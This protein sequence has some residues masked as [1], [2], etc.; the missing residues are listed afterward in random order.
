MKDEQNFEVELMS[1]ESKFIELYPVTASGS[2]ILL[3]PWQRGYA[4]DKGHLQLVKKSRR[5][6]FTFVEAAKGL[7]RSQT[8]ISDSIPYAYEKHFISRNLGEAQEFITVARIIY[9]CLP[10]Q[11]RLRIVNET[12]REL[13]FEDIRGRRTRLKAHTANDPRGIGGDL[14]YDEAAFLRNFSKLYSAG[15]WVTARGGDI[16]IGSSPGAASGHFYE[17]CENKD[18]RFSGFRRRNIPWWLSH[19]LC[20]DVARAAK[21]ASSMAT[22]D[23]VYEFGTPEII[24]IFDS[25]AIADFQQ[26]SE[27]MY[28][29]ES[30]TFFPYELIGSCSVGEFGADMKDSDVTMAFSYCKDEPDESFWRWVKANTKGRL[31]GGFDVG[32]RRDLS[33]LVLTDAYSGVREVRAVVTLDRKDF[34]SQERVINDCIRIAKPMVIR[35]E[36]NGL[37]MEMGERLKKQWG[38]LIELVTSSAPWKLRAATHLKYLFEKRGIRIPDEPDLVN[39]IHS[40][41]KTINEHTSNI[42][43]GSDATLHHGDIT[44]ALILAC[45]ADGE[46]MIEKFEPAF[47]KNTRIRATPFDYDYA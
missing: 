11:R 8:R 27:C 31:E 14:T 10:S 41:K 19:R 44:W 28:A 29:D 13:I 1:D 18:N 9:D 22:R 38:S 47:G 25:A 20:V 39:N 32:R 15:Q 30:A 36:E 7:A 35:Y 2:N 12:K 43:F 24:R 42:M 6:G 23:R 21:E 40:I 3:D 4:R 33:A 17:M 46:T 5:T 34:P 16:A 26:E 37:G 45:Y